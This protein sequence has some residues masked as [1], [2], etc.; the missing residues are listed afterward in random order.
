VAA[1]VQRIVYTSFLACSP[2]ATFTFARDH[3]HT[4]EHIRQAG[5][6]HTFLRDSLYLDVFPFFAGGDG[7]IRGPAGDGRVAAVARDDIAD[8]AVAVLLGDGHDGRTYDLTGPRAFTLQEAAEELS[9]ASGRTVTY[10]AETMEEAYASRAG[11]G[12]PHWE[13]TGWVTTYAAIAT[14]ELDIVSDHVAAIAGHPPM[15]LTEFLR[16][17]PDSLQHLVKG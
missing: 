12:A 7:V 2:D 11:Y 3:W 13:V 4:E 15:D 10:H 6:R 1:G 9:R 5:V 14:G 8:V 16:R 17:N